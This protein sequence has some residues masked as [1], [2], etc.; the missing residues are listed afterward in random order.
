MHRCLFCTRVGV[1]AHEC[2]IAR[3]RGRQ[4]CSWAHVRVRARARRLRVDICM[5][6]RVC[7]CVL[8]CL[9]LL[10]RA[11]KSACVDA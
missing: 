2:V 5:A 9:C 3:V 7:A 4:T 6:V 8:V 11:C 10:E 1:L